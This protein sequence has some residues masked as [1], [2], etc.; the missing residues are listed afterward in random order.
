MATV[1]DGALRYIIGTPGPTAGFLTWDAA[2]SVMPN[3]DKVIADFE[4]KLLTRADGT[5]FA[6]WSTFGGAARADGVKL[7]A[8]ELQGAAGMAWASAAPVAGQLA[9]AFSLFADDEG[10]PAVFYV[11]AG[12]MDVRLASRDA[13][14]QWMRETVHAAGFAAV[15]A[16]RRHQH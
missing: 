11:G 3:Q 15:P 13:H 9:R 16:L 6:L 2:W 10:N 14:G 4:V 7:R 1:G 12:D 8:V 5:L